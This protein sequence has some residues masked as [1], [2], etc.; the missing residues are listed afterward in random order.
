M[1]LEGGVKFSKVVAWGEPAGTSLACTA[2][3]DNWIKATDARR[4]IER[5]IVRFTR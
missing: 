4:R 1:A 5:R 3:A 2:R